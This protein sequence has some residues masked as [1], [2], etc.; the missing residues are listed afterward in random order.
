M[1]YIEV[2]YHSGCS[3]EPWVL[4]TSEHLRDESDTE[5][6][7]TDSNAMST[8]A[9]PMMPGTSDEFALTP[10]SLWAY[11]GPAILVPVF[12]L[13]WTV[14][15]VCV[16][17]E[18]I[19]FLGARMAHMW[20]MPGGLPAL[21]GSLF[22]LQI[23]VPV[24]FVFLFALFVLLSGLPLRFN[25]ELYEISLVSRTLA[26]IAMLGLTLG[27]VRRFREVT[28]A[29]IRFMRRLNAQYMFEDNPKQP[30]FTGHMTVVMNIVLSF[31]AGTL[32][33]GYI[34]GAMAIM[35]V[36][37]DGLET[38][39]S[40]ERTLATGAVIGFGLLRV[41]W[42]ALRMQI[43]RAGGPEANTESAILA[44]IE[45]NQRRRIVPRPPQA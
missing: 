28:R 8:D 24:T 19:L 16:G 17:Y 36:V 13:D 40:E 37:A 27:A 38:F 33:A 44:R 11:L 20:V 1:I 35:N 3:C 15:A 26:V 29:R 32:A 31:F 2:R 12:G 39:L 7:V 9:A 4:R 14:F 10:A 6:A 34:F 25:G 30:L 22:M 41:A 42:E 43:R 23:I 18:L 45:R 21:I 5:A